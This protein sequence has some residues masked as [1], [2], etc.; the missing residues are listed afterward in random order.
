MTLR[1]VFGAVVISIALSGCFG[2][3]QVSPSDPLGVGGLKPTQEDKDAGLVGIAPGFNLKD[4]EIIAVERIPVAKSEIEDAGDQRFADTMAAFYQS[5]VVRRLRETGLFSRVVNLSETDFPTGAGK[6]LRL[7]GTITRL[8]RGSQA[9]RYLVGF[10]AGSTRAQT[11]MHFAD[12]ESG[13]VVIVTADRR[14]GSMGLFGGDDEEFLRESFNNMAR[15][16]AKFLTRLTK[17]E[18]QAA[19]VVKTS[20]PTAATLTPAAPGTTAG[21]SAGLKALVGTWTGT[22][23]GGAELRVRHD[24]TYRIFEEGGEIRW[25]GRRR[26]ATGESVGSGTVALSEDGVVLTGQR[27]ESRSSRVFPVALTLTRRGR[28]LEA[29]VLGSDNRVYFIVV[30]RNQ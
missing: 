3:Y 5:E 18:G 22:M 17:G 26:W 27:R 16:L 13:R 30:T 19:L 25:E 1:N 11:E 14:L 2:A 23:T 29:T 24:V 15:D 9:A 7:H 28:T 12:A 8:D 4:Y 10:G 20:Q 6:A 21:P